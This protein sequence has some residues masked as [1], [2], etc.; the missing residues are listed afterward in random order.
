MPT[1]SAV[2]IVVCI[3]LRLSPACDYLAIMTVG[4]TIDG[5]I[6]APSNPHMW[7]VPSLGPCSPNV[8]RQCTLNLIRFLS[9]STLL[10]AQESE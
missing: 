4:K 5:H 6:T 2:V 8:G 9:E 3:S 10:V 1:C 7:V